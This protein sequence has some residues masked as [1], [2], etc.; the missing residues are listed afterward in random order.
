ML[1]DGDGQHAEGGGEGGVGG[2]LGEGMELRVLV[3][4]VEEGATTS[5]G[6]CV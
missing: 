3:D 5:A 4:G 2:Q 1:V 6:V